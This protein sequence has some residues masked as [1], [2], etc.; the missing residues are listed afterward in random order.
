VQWRFTTAIRCNDEYVHEVAKEK[1]AICTA[2]TPHAAVDGTPV[3]PGYDFHVGGMAEFIDRR[4]RDQTLAAAQKLGGVAPRANVTGLQ[5]TAMIGGT[6]LAASAWACAGTP[7]R[8]G[9]NATASDRLS[10]NVMSTRCNRSRVNLRPVAP[11]AARFQRGDGGAIIVRGEHLARSPAEMPA[12]CK[13]RISSSR[14]LK[15]KGAMQNQKPDA[16]LDD[17]IDFGDGSFSI[18]RNP[19]SM[20]DF[21]RRLLVQQSPAAPADASNARGR[22]VPLAPSNEGFQ[23]GMCAVNKRNSHA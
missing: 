10:S 21:C 7:W 17:V 18:G 12:R 6:P 5:D 8:G 1:F 15:G 20:T 4:D 9:P 22:R 11:A 23:S 19:R 13:R 14:P 16:V 3:Q 2:V